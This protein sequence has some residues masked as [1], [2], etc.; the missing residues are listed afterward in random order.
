MSRETSMTLATVG[1]S[2]S[3]PGP[4]LPLLCLLRVSNEGTSALMRAPMKNCGEVSSARAWAPRSG[5]VPWPPNDRAADTTP[6]TVLMAT[7]IAVSTAT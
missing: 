7:L 1:S 2:P 3:R 6:A 4:S 5:T